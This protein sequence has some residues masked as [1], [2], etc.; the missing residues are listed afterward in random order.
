L[1]SSLPMPIIAIKIFIQNIPGIEMTANNHSMKETANTGG[2][3][4]SRDKMTTGKD[5]HQNRVC[6]ENYHFLFEQATDAIMVTDFKGNFKNANSGLCAMFGYTREEL[7]ELNVKALLDEE[8]VKAN[9]L[10]FDLLAAG[11]NIFNERKMVHKNGTV[12]YVEANAKKFMDDRI[13]VIARDI[14]DR[15]K[16][17]QVLQKSEANLHTIF[18]T[19]DTIYVLMDHDLRIISYN[20]CAFAFAK[21]EL[22]HSIEISEYLLDYFPPEK[23]PQ[24]LHY[25]KEVLAGRHISYEVSYPQA[26][27]LFNYYHVRMFPISKGDSN[28]YGLM[29]AVSDITEEKLLE[30]KLLDQK[31]QEQKRIIRAVLQAQ[32]IERNRIGQELHDNVNQVLTCIKMYLG[33]LEKGE[34]YRKD[35]VEKSKEFIDNAIQEIRL[36]SS[37]QVTPQKKV[38]IRELI[39]ELTKRLN[40]KTNTGTKFHCRVAGNLSIDESLKLNIYRIVQEQVNNILKYAHASQATISINENNNT[41]YVSIIDNGNGFDPAIKRKGIGI[42]NIINRIESYNGEVRIVSSP[43]KGCKL[44]IRIPH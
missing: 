18:D 5:Q 2:E 20:P 10:R 26:K 19:T 17:E 29:L 28:I 12:I 13:L 3:N 34:T 11:E 6:T 15:K 32:E 8:H 23:Q 9:P 21:K 35:L 33:L 30:Q 1:H 16:V 25:M 36:L 38:D 7:L 24:L 39:E 44:E 42:S 37:Q 27:G 4:T 22:G 14:T 43:G 41:V 31:I 40:E